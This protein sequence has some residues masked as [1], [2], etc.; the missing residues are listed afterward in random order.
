[1]AIENKYR[2]KDVATDFGK[3]TK[4]ITEILTKYADTPKSSMQALNDKELS[5]IFEVITQN[6]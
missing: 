6:E 3:T 2:V 4:E 5:M 1:M